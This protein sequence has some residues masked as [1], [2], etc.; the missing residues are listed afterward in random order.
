MS[1]LEGRFFMKI[2]QTLLV[3]AIVESLSAPW[4]A[5]ATRSPLRR[6]RPSATAPGAPDV[7]APATPATRR[8]PPRPAAKHACKGKNDCKGQGGC[9]SD[10]NSCKGQNACKGQAAARRPEL[11]ARNE[12]RKRILTL[13]SSKLFLACHGASDVG[14]TL[15]FFGD[16]SSPV[17]AST[18]SR[19]DGSSTRESFLASDLGIG[20]GLRT[21]HYTHILEHAPPSIGVE[22]LS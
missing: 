16:F 1:S 10:K 20:L 17:T 5:A 8:R 19:V 21:V 18:S 6:I 22:I 2:S 7:K 14:F 3:A 15:F 13:R 12:L 9:K 4:R 11:D